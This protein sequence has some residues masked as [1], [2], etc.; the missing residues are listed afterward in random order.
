[1]ENNISTDNCHVTTVGP[2]P[3]EPALSEVIR[4]PDNSRT[5]SHEREVVSWAG[6]LGRQFNWTQFHG[7]SP[8]D[9]TKHSK[10]K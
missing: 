6:Q 1:M 7:G 8:D 2:D 5:H 9:K 10:R 4:E 3:R